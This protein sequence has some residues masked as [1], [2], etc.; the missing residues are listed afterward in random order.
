MG[1]KLQELSF[2]VGD[3][4]YR[5]DLIVCLARRPV[6]GQNYPRKAWITQVTS[7]LSASNRDSNREKSSSVFLNVVIF[8]NLEKAAILIKSI[9][10]PHLHVSV[11]FTLP[12]DW[13][14]FLAYKTF[15]W[16]EIW[17]VSIENRKRI[18]DFRPSA[19]YKIFAPTRFN[20]NIHRS[21]RLPKMWHME[22][23]TACHFKRKAGQLE[24][25]FLFSQW[26]SVKIMN[27]R[28]SLYNTIQY[29]ISM[30]KPENKTQVFNIK[31]EKKT[32]FQIFCNSNKLVEI[33]IFFLFSR[34][35]DIFDERDVSV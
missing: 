23:N 19:R 25:L 1:R 16:C 15:F 4:L 27:G 17:V 10:L 13:T 20:K 28:W 12:L 6:S 31:W 21:Y 2:F 9:C 22:R 30:Y 8:P 5:S 14:G 26:H 29:Y 11:N 33:V 34:N 3:G 32:L 7:F 24:F 35:N 18:A